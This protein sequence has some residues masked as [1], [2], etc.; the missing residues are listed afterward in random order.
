MLTVMSKE[1]EWATRVAEW[2]SS[3]LSGTKFCEERGISVATLYWWSRRLKRAQKPSSKRETVRLARVVR[4][5]VSTAPVI[6]QVGLARVEIT[7]DVDRET[8][9]IVFE[10]LASSMGSAR[11]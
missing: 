1:D 5:Q 9:L 2:K 6:V 7:T 8:L 10:A 3:G 4:S 11:S